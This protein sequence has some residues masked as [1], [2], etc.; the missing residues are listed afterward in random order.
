MLLYIIQ[1]YYYATLRKRYFIGGYLDF[2][3]EL[4]LIYALWRQQLWL[5]ISL[6]VMRCCIPWML[7]KNFSKLNYLLGND[8]IQASIADII[9]NIQHTKGSKW[10]IILIMLV[11]LL[12]YFMLYYHY[13]IA[14]LIL[15]VLI[16]L[17]LLCFYLCY[18]YYP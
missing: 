3:L 10:L 17:K 18:K 8:K 5:V 2:I 13:L 9:I 12:T 14:Y 16:M 4:G 1:F 6:V 11:Y 7:P 15:L